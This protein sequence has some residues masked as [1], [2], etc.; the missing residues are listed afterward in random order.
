M[1]DAESCILPLA[2]AR[3]GNRKAL[4]APTDQAIHAANPDMAEMANPLSVPRQS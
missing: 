4:N 1:A 2:V 3:L